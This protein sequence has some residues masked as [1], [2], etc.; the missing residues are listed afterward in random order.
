MKVARFASFPLGILVLHLAFVANSSDCV[1]RP[2]EHRQAPL[3]TGHDH[4]PDSDSQSAQSPGIT[5]PVCCQA[6]ASC[7]AATTVTSTVRHVVPGVEAHGQFSA[8]E[9]AL[10]ALTVAP[11]APPPRA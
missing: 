3:P 11:E 8:R 2:T 1:S 9:H 4:H 6:L 5:I 7:S 10:T